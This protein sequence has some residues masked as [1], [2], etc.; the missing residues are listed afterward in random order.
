MLCRGCGRC[1]DSG[2]PIDDPLSPVVAD[3][4]RADAV[5]FASPVRFNGLSSQM[6]ALADRLNMYWYGKVPGGRKAYGI[7]VGGSPEPEFRH[8]L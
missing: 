2:C 7:L 3:V 5:V 4:A 6:K 1:R 8:A